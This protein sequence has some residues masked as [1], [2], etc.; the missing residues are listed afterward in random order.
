MVSVLF[1]KRRADVAFEMRCVVGHEVR[2]FAMLCVTPSW[3]DR[4][5][6]RRVGGQPLDIDVLETRGS[7]PL[8]GRAM[9]G[10]AIPADDHRPSA[11]TAKLFHKR[12]YVLSANVTLL[13]LKWRADVTSSGRE[14]DSAD[15][16]Q[17]VVP[18]PGTLNGRF[19]AWRP[20]AA[21]HRLK[22]KSS[23]IDKN[24]AGASPASFFLIRGQSPRRHRS[25]VSESC[26]RATHLG[27]WGEKPRS[28]STRPMWAGWYETPNCSRTTS[29][30]RAHVHKSVRYPTATGPWRRILVNAPLCFSQSFGSGPGCGLAAKPSTPSAFH[31]LFQRFTLVKLTPKSEATSR[32]GFRSWKCSAARRRRASS[33]VALPGGLMKHNTLLAAARVLYQCCG[34]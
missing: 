11:M 17:P 33:S 19:T 20:S 18:V 10:P 15:H 34:Q 30:T 21:I 9:H 8:G 14:R 16:A 2:Q 23:F 22:L 12:D 5:Q 28:C 24:N 29:E 6:L 13:N 32:R 1:S 4:V 27:F 3:L 26:S 31:V 25:T 7:E